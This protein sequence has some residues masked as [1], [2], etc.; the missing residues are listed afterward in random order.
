MTVEMESWGTLG[1]GWGILFLQVETVR[2]VIQAGSAA[3][4]QEVANASH[5]GYHYCFLDTLGLASLA[6]LVILSYSAGI[7]MTS[8]C[9]KT[10]AVLSGAR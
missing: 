2:E 5:H 8:S 1:P 4:Y 3:T 10:E 6:L 7:W 9:S